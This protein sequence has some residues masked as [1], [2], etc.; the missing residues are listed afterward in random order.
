M[1]QLIYVLDFRERES[2]G[3][4]DLLKR[5]IIRYFVSLE[6]IVFHIPN[7]QNFTRLHMI[8]NVNLFIIL[9]KLRTDVLKK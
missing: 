6:N 2:Y 7:I 4:A 8:K 9:E 3:I 1:I 5:N